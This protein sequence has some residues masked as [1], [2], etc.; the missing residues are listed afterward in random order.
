MSQRDSKSV[1]IDNRFREYAVYDGS[2]GRIRVTVFD[3][4]FAAGVDLS[5]DK[6]GRIPCKCSIRFRRVGRNGESAGRNAL[7]GCIRQRR[8]S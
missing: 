4:R 2:S 7:D 1:K 8:G 3:P 6:R 5:Q